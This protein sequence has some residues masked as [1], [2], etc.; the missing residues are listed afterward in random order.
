[1]PVASSVLL[2]KQREAA[3]TITSKISSSLGHGHQLVP[4]LVHGRFDGAIELAPCLVDL[5]PDAKRR[6][7]VRQVSRLRPYA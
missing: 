4:A 1:V 2:K 5:W 3:A 6:G 7:Q